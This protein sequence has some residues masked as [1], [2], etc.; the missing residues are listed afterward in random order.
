M[1]HC[2]PHKQRRFG[3]PMITSVQT[4]IQGWS[5]A[6]RAMDKR[7]DKPTSKRPRAY[8]RRALAAAIKNVRHIR[9]EQRRR[10]RVGVPDLVECWQRRLATRHRF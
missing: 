3:K 7:S 9:I 8:A 10:E 5:R 6:G 4:A 2:A 1:R